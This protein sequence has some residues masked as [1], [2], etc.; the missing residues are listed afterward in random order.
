VSLKYPKNED[1]SIALPTSYA[2]SG[3]TVSSVAVN[4]YAVL[5]CRG[6]LVVNAA[7]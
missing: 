1:A 4:N 2:F 7:S 5:L 3:D 6:Y